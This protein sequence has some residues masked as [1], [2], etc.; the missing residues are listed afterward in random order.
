MPY[1][2]RSC[3]HP[4]EQGSAQLK[5][6]PMSA[7]STTSISALTNLCSR[8]GQSGPGMTSTAFGL[9]ALACMDDKDRS[10]GTCNRQWTCQ[11]RKAGLR[12][13][14]CPSLSLGVALRRAG[15]AAL[16]GKSRGSGL[17]EMPEDLTSCQNGGKDAI[18]VSRG[19]HQKALGTQGICRKLRVV[20]KHRQA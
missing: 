9:T 8:S 2:I 19:A 17:R 4:L 3:M 6:G 10:S 16:P 13:R 15:L 5:P 20:R 7:N 12:V 11:M 1:F 14:S 18:R